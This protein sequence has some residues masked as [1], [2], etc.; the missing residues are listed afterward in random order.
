MG[1]HS[2]KK[3][4]LLPFFGDIQ[5]PQKFKKIIRTNSYNLID[6]LALYLLD[7]SKRKNLN[8]GAKR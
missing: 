2:V 6:F 5:K 7:Y 1:T 8:L 4:K 3:R